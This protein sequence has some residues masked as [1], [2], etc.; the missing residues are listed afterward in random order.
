MAES[1]TGTA[2]PPTGLCTV[3]SRKSSILS[4][5]WTPQAIFNNDDIASILDS[6]V[7]TLEMESKETH[8]EILNANKNTLKL[9]LQYIR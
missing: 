7:N 3:G 4:G 8:L 2:P 9:N 1:M 5:L 6:L